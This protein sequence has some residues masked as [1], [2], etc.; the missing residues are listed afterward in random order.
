MAG[1]CT[2]KRDAALPWYRLP[3]RY[4]TL[5]LGVRRRASKRLAAAIEPPR[6]RR[7]PFGIDPGATPVHSSMGTRAGPVAFVPPHGNHPHRRKSSPLCLF[8]RARAAVRSER[9][10]IALLEGPPTPTLVSRSL[11][12]WPPNP[13]APPNV[14]NARLLFIRARGMGPAKDH[15]SAGNNATARR[16][17]RYYDCPATPAS[18]RRSLPFTAGGTHYPRCS[19]DTHS[20]AEIRQLFRTPA[21]VLPR[22]EH[23]FQFPAVLA[24]ETLP[25]RRRCPRDPAGYPRRRSFTG[26]ANA[27]RR[28]YA[29]SHQA[30]PLPPPLLVATA[31]GR[32]GNAE[33]AKHPIPSDRRNTTRQTKQHVP[34]GLG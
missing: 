1:A 13:V 17:R 25:P 8:P 32:S 10:C 15:R 16:G 34:D 26:A 6:G 3:R 18:H 9:L 12:S 22:P 33:Q 2:R 28:P 7:G 11:A 14:P 20:R 21:R 31:A 30:T 19:T 29:T 5:V 24:R 23:H 27:S 4:K